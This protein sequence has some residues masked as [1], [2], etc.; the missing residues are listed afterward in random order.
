[1]KLQLS[2]IRDAL[3]LQDL[4][5]QH[6]DSID[7]GLQAIETGVKTEWG[8]LVFALDREGRLVILLIDAAQDDALLSRLIGIYG[9]VSRTVPLL[10]R[11]YAKRG[12]N[13][14]KVP[15]VVVIA[16]DFS[17]TVEDGLAYLSFQV[18]AYRQRCIEINGERS[19]LI[20]CLQ[21][22]GVETNGSEKARTLLKA[23]DLTA[24]EIQFFEEDNVFQAK[25]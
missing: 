24:A 25:S 21:T 1:V 9:W 16:P 2:P 7:E 5:L 4:T 23:A 14:R 22:Q 17:R 18:D 13:G 12:L 19:L 3:V 10:N 8:L 15:K 11:Y 6:L 20:E